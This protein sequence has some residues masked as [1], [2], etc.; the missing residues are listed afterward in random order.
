MKTLKKCIIA[1]FCLFQF[2]NII[3]AQIGTVKGYIKIHSNTP[4]LTGFLDNTDYF[5]AGVEYLGDLN[6]DGNGDYAVGS[7]MDDDGGTNKG[8]FYI[9]FCDSNKGILNV[10][11]ISAWFG[12]FTGSISTDAYFGQVIKSIGDYDNDGIKDLIVA[13]PNDNDNGTQK[14]SFFLLLM[15]SNGTVKSTL[16]YAA[17]TSSVLSTTITNYARFGVAIDTIG[18][19]NHDGVKDLAVGGHAYRISGVG[20]GAFWILFMNSNGTVQSTQIITNSQGGFT[21]TIAAGNYFGNAVT[22]LGDLNKDG[23]YDIAVSERENDEGGTNKGAVYIFFMNTNGTVKGF[24]KIN[25]L[26]GNFTGVLNPS[27]YFGHAIEDLGDING[28]NI[29]DIA[30]GCPDL[31]NNTGKGKV[32]IIMLNTSGTVKAY[33]KIGQGFGNFTGTIGAQEDFGFSLAF[34]HDFNKDGKR[35]LLVGTRRDNTGGSNRGAA[36]IL[37]FNSIPVARISTSDPTSFCSGKSA[38]LIADTINGYSYRWLRNDTLING[39]NLYYYNAT[40]PGTYKLIVTYKNVNDTSNSINITVYNNPTAH[41]TA[42]DTTI[43]CQGNSTR[44]QADSIYGYS[45]K[46]LKNNS[47]I[48]GMNKSILTVKTSGNYKVIVSN[49]NCSDTSQSQSVIVNS[50]PPATVIT[51]GSTTFCQGNSLLMKAPSSVNYNYV[52]KRNG[53]LISGAKDSIYYASLSGSY[54]VIIKD[55]NACSD[56][57]SLINVAVNP[58]PPA[59][60]NAMGTTSFCQGGSVTL[61]ANTASGLTYKWKRDYQIISGAN[62]SSY[63]ATLGGIYQVVVTDQNGCSDS[64]ATININVFQLPVTNINITGLTTFCQGKSALLT[65]DS[66]NGYSFIWLLNGN[67]Y[68]GSTS[69]CIAMTSGNFQV[70]V[71]DGRC[72]D[73]SQVYTILVNP[74][75]PTPIILRSGKYLYSSSSFGNQWYDSSGPIPGAND[76]VYKPTANGKYFV[77]VTNFKGCVSDTSNVILFYSDIPE[78]Q[79]FEHIKIY[80]N[81]NSGYFIIENLAPGTI[82]IRIRDLNGKFIQENMIGLKEKREFSIQGISTGIYLLEVEVNG[83]NFSKKFIIFK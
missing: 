10:Q 23:I 29:V 31:A 4:Q 61:N 18:D 16:K 43:F 73:T 15:N 28:D 36:Y 81:P 40:L 25:D 54:R 52:W 62:L 71:S 39:A 77:L 24:Q 76:T 59:S 34:I 68:P 65:A 11:K 41:L 42:L 21:G 51:V 83:E 66:L 72:S 64:S 8:A 17:S 35:D 14:G 26:Y 49:L 48:S 44:L 12:N 63:L 78:D 60:L 47:L 5:G 33:Q 82:I 74:K 70:I 9:F 69:H 38:R 30:V 79:C 37:Y 46:W 20:I 58:L 56:S 1:F 13:A 27:D 3:H 6:G 53:N 57:S 50:L 55:S 75:P 67:I 45:F 32:F 80:P 19:L 2:I 22:C 7:P